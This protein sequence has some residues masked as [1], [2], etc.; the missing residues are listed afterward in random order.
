MGYIYRNGRIYDP[1][2]NPIYYKGKNIT[3]VY[4]NGVT[5]YFEWDGTINVRDTYNFEYGGNYTMDYSD[6]LNG[7]EFPEVDPDEGFTDSF[8]ITY[9]SNYTFNYTDG[10]VSIEQ[11]EES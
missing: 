9:G 4:R 5:Y 11:E 3:K 1:K 8:S 7:I 10:G 2:T 6:V